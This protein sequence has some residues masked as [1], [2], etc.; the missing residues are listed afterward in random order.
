MI[1]LSVFVSITLILLGFTIPAQGSDESAVFT[2][3]AY[4]NGPGG[5]AIRE[6]NYDAAIK[7]ARHQRRYVETRLAAQNNLCVIYTMEDISVKAKRACKKAVVLAAQTRRQNWTS[8]MGYKSA[9]AQALSNRAIMRASFGDDDGARNDL[10]KAL[11]LNTEK[12][13]YADN[14]AVL[15]ENSDAMKTAKVDYR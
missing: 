6:G 3:V 14:L 7:I 4:S 10:I 11:T 8:T 2:L 12:V 1:K 13:I 9:L 15:K 5:K